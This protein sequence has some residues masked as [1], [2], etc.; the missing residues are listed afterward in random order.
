M[1]VAKGFDWT[2]RE[3]SRLG[4][5]VVQIF[6]K[7]PRSWARKTWTDEERAAFS[8]L[9]GSVPV[10]AH[11]TYL[12]NLA[13]I[14]EDHRHMEGFVHEVDLSLQLGIREMVVHCGS[15]ADRRRG[16]EMV[17]RAVNRILSTHGIHIMLENS[18]GQGRS[19]GTGLE[20]L[21]LIYGLIEQQQRVSL[22]IDTAH[23]FAAGYDIGTPESW[24]TV[25][26]TIEDSFGTGKIGLFH[27]NDS[28]SGMG[29]RSD[30]HWHIGKGAI[31]PEAF[32]MILNDGRFKNIKGVMETPKVDDMDEQNMKFLRS[33]LPPLV[34]RS[35][36]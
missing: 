28:K 30:R 19:L 8:R 35:S 16:V 31:G 18:A 9:S 10:V 27:L 7:N 4:C 2:L 5:E 1:S 24:Q 25:V 20:E 6:V 23:L 26:S 36:S 12:P 11:L 34:S 29:S 14:D 13:R 15:R 32:K 21:R 33:L 17:A 3:A 22:C